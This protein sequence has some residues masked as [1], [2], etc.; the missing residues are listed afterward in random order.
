MRMVKLICMSRYLLKTL[1]NIIVLLGGK[2]TVNFWTTHVGHDE[3]ELRSKHLSTLEKTIVVEKLK[4]GIPV[5]RIL[6]DA[7]KLNTS[8]IERYNLL[9]R[10][11]V[12]YLLRKHNVEKKRDKDEMLA[13]ALKVQEWNAN[14]RNF[15][16]FF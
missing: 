5:D 11:D 15:V 3:E 12:T 1:I 7:R 10:M 16:F 2:V 9:S 4:S 13:A 14:S 6:E 8:K